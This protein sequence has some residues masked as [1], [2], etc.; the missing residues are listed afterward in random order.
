MKHETENISATDENS[1][2]PPD[3]VTSLTEDVLVNILPINETHELLNQVALL[4]V[5][6]CQRCSTNFKI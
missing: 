5:G 3:H 4:T 1:A 2:I 6:Y